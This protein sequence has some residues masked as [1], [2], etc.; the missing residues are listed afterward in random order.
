MRMSALRSRRGALLPP[1]ESALDRFVGE[2][3]IEWKA[4][5]NFAR[6]AAE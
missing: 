6:I 2:C 4:K 5:P 1:L 3:E